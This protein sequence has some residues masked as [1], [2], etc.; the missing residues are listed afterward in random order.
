LG[1]DDFVAITYAFLDSTDYLFRCKLSNTIGTNIKLNPVI[2]EGDSYIEPVSSC[3]LDGEYIFINFS[4]GTT[5]EVDTTFGQ[6]RLRLSAIADTT[7]SFTIDEYS[8]SMNEFPEENRTIALLGDSLTA[9]STA[10]YGTYIDDILL[11]ATIINAGV[12]GNTLEDMNSRFS[13]D[14]ANESPDVCIL[15]GGANDIGDGRTLDQ[16]QKSVQS[17]HSKCIKNNIEL[18]CCSMSAGY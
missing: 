1:A 9:E 4:T 18:I 2:K 16:M 7:V 13:S 11:N 15:L 14:I 5:D 3:Y 8:L 6:I 12:A 10:G 17:I